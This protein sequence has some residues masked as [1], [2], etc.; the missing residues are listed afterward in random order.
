MKDDERPRIRSTRRL[1]ENS[2]YQTVQNWEDQKLKAIGELVEDLKV[3]GVQDLTGL[4]AEMYYDQARA[5]YVL[6]V[7]VPAS[8][9][10]EDW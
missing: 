7:S 10:P 3:D 9:R 5:D 2:I 4:Q 8:A 6:A 1:S